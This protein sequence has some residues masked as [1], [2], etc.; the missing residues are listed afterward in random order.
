VHRNNPALG[1][2]NL[3]GIDDGLEGIRQ[4]DAVFLDIADT[5]GL[6]Q[7]LKG[8]EEG[9]QLGQTP[10]GTVNARRAMDLQGDREGA[11]IL[12]HCDSPRQSKT[13]GERDHL[14][15]GMELALYILLAVWLYLAALTCG[16]MRRLNSL[17]EEQEE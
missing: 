17:R 12:A 10:R 15:L 6:E 3:L 2:S 1:E 13:E 14:I 5:L 8:W 16:M 9:L 4:A 7:S 11:K